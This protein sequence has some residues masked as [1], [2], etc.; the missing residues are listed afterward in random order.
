MRRRGLVHRQRELATLARRSREVVV[1]AAGVGVVTGAIVAAVD[2]L[3]VEIAV[4]HL[5]TLATWW[6]VVLPGVGLVAAAL[7]LRWL[8]AGASPS[9]SD[10][11]LRAFHDR[12]YP[13]TA[14]PLLARLA[15]SIATLGTGG[16]LGLE[17]PA[18]YAGSVVGASAQR[19]WL[20]RFAT[21][22][23]RVLMVAGAAAGVAAIF[24]APATGAVFALEVPYRDDLARRMLLPALVASVSGYLTFVAVHGT[25]PRFLAYGAGDIA[26]R[27]LIGAV[28]VGLGAAF[29]ARLFAAALRWAKR[30]ATRRLAGRIAA[31]AVTLAGVGA[32]GVA[33]TGEPLMLGPGYQVIDWVS[34]PSISVW[35][36]AAILAL[37]CAA[38]VATVAG[39]GVGGLFIPLVV[40]GALLGEGV[41]RVVAPDEVSLFPVLGVA[42][43]LG[44]GYRV[45]LAA[46]MFVSETTGRPGFVVPGVIAAVIADLVMA[47]SSIT[48]YQREPGAP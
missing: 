12:A 18:L 22:D 38:T 21:S 7:I 15:A 24:K 14:R 8:G 19:R 32:L 20:R 28:M 35:L 34:D 13:L 27:E 41:G 5:L 26:A 45:P 4:H 29:G 11:Y 36:I 42:A 30:F 16:A 1:I 2:Q 23:P 6:Q 43:F 48:V 46:V 9:T 31:S 25:E 37:R 17:G 39:G 44:A 47:D 3:V 33:L 40:A 10:E